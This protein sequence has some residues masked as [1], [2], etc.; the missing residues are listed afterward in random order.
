MNI[1]QSRRQIEIL[2][3]FADAARPTLDRSRAFEN[4]RDANRVDRSKERAAD[5]LWKN[6][7]RR[8]GP[9]ACWPWRSGPA[10]F[11]GPTGSSKTP[12][13]VAWWVEHGALPPTGSRLDVTCGND[14]C[15]NPRHLA[16]V[17]EAR[18]TQKGV[19]RFWLKVDKSAGKDGCW[20]WTGPRFR[21]GA[22][23]LYTGKGNT[24]ARRFIWTETNGDPGKQLVLAT[25]NDQLC[26]NPSHL[27][28]GT[29]IDKARQA[30]ESGTTERVRQKNASHAKRRAG[31]AM[32][33]PRRSA[34]PARRR[35]PSRPKTA[36]V[37]DV[38]ASAVLGLR[39]LL[40]QARAEVVRIETAIKLVTGEA[41]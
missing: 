23:L 39:A 29:H 6:V 34:Q 37:P 24:G 2:K 30:R 35:H 26:M 20:R 10:R 13:H 38:R 7:D 32:P 4:Q 14:K 28:L 18:D 3:E 22:A 21:N 8:G 41:M 15:C 27:F 1:S 16:H 31:S 5:W 36:P 25:C 9:D 11:T 33:P 12:R 17:R 19:D 40:D